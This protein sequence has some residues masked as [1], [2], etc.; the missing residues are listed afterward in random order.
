MIWWVYQQAK[1][2]PQLQEVYAAID[3]KNVQNVCEDLGIPY[4][5]TSDTMPEHISRVHEVANK[6]SADYYLCINGDEPLVSPECISQ[7]IPKHVQPSCFFGGAVRLLTNPAETIDFANIKVVLTAAG[8]CLYLSRTPVPYPRGTLLFNYYKYVGIECFDKD[9][10]DFFVRTPQGY[11]EKI[12]DIDHL[13]FLENGVELHFTKVDSES[14]SVDT[15]KDL[16]KVR[17]MVKARL[18]SGELT[19]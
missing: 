16:E 12:E 17:L 15:P 5:M 9:V 10:L 3:N 7:I 11:V 19:L 2:V 1:K 6:I 8:K 14:I 13:R 18:E 4:V